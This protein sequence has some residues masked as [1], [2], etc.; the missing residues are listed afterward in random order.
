MYAS[1][2]LPADRPRT[3]AG[4]LTFSDSIGR[5]EIGVYVHAIGPLG[6]A[7]TFLDREGAE[8]VISALR[9]VF[10]APLARSVDF[11]AL[12]GGTPVFEATDED[13]D[14][15]R[16]RV[17]YGAS[18]LVET[19]SDGVLLSAADVDRLR[20]AL[21][22]PR[23]SDERVRPEPTSVGTVSVNAKA[24]LQAA[25]VLGFEGGAAVDAAGFLLSRP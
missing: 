6:S 8:A 3:H 12:E 18:L 22:V 14:T 23:E 11:G 9:E 20:V 21:S 19:P 13:G 16:V 25:L 2:P 10:P 5:P 4:T 17:A 15:L 7:A 1:I 24:A